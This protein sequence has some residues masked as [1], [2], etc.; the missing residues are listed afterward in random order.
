MAAPETVARWLDLLIAQTSFGNV[1]WAE[2]WSGDGWQYAAT[3]SV[4][5]IFPRDGDGDL[6][7]ILKVSSLNGSQANA[8]T[9]YGSGIG[10]EGE[11]PSW[12]WIQDPGAP[13]AAPEWLASRVRNLWEVVNEQV[14]T[15]PVVSM[16]T[17]LEALPPF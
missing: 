7:Y 16:L 9:A 6:P 4:V 15:D 5:E 1:R 12:D 3:D 2:R 11:T 14:G 10:A 8:W 13:E 17:D